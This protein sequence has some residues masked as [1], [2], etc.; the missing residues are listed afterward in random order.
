MSNT[1][2]VMGQASNQYVAPLQLEDVFST[3]L[4]EGNSS[5]QTITNGIDLDGEGGLVWIKR[6][7]SADRHALF[8]S[9]RGL[10]Y[11]LASNDDAANRTRTGWMSSF[12]TNGF[13]LNTNDNEVN[14]NGNDYASWT[15]RKAP[16]FFDVVTYTGTGVASRTVSH[17]LGTTVGMIMVK[18]TDVNGYHWT[19]YHRGAAGKWGKTNDTMAFTTSSVGYQF[20]D[21]T[22]A[23][24]PTSTE[25][26]VGSGASVNE[27][28]GTYVAYLFA[29][30]DGD[31]GF[32]ADDDLDI[33]KCGSFTGGGDVAV[34]VGFEPQ[35]VLTKA[36]GLS[37]NW[38]IHDTMRGYTADA[39]GQATLHPNVSDAEDTGIDAA[40]TSTGFRTINSSSGQNYIY[41]AIRRGTK[42]PES[43][44]EVFAIDTA[45]STGNAP[46]V[47]NSGFPVDMAF[48]NVITGGDRTVLSRMTGGQY[49]KLNDTNAEA[50]DDD[51]WDFMDG[52]YDG[53][54][55]N[56]NFYSWMWKR[57]PGFFDVVAYTGDGTANQE[58][59]H[60]LT[61]IPDM[62]WI[63]NRGRAQDW[64]VW[65]DDN[66]TTLEGRL[67][68][69]ED[70]GYNVIGTVTNTTV[71]TLN[72][73]QYAT[74]YNGDN[75]IAYL[76][77]SVDGVSKVGSY[78]GTGA[79]LNIDCG[80][81]SGARFV[82]IK[83]TDEAKDWVL[84]DTS[85][86][87]VA[88]NDDY[89]LLN[90]TDANN[91][92]NAD[93]ID[94]YSAGF[95]LTGVSSLTNESGGNYIFYAIA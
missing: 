61:T 72:T 59:T 7:S 55:T 4:Y 30:N 74:N 76:F 24:A 12:N 57:A 84:F 23:I 67:N 10:N 5:T 87:I 92:G 81:T 46:P 94:P 89:L 36:T 11:A 3:Y 52:W 45:N 47:W 95:S 80:F 63:K 29:H 15:L 43:A 31:G 6:R 62:V 25:F 78:T 22:S 37:Q 71:Q 66:I 8:D 50:F 19:V 90:K 21:N 64:W 49:L 53:S 35:W 68:S 2:T 39:T 82:L 1:K 28:G 70:F 86:G 88:G 85:R 44:T 41:M 73:N 26:T 13:T 18:R 75:Y 14:L 79:T 42:V 83:K 60:S 48:Y 9:E 27:S 56:S 65:V 58:F 77:G 34:D 17:N 38:T 16:K 54:F 40:L 51:G 93:F 32:G 91:A 33:I 69:S 20:G